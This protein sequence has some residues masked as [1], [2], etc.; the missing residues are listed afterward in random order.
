M[1]QGQPSYQP[2]A[3]PRFYV[4]QPPHNQTGC[5]ILHGF[6]ASPDEVAWLGDDLAQQG[7]RVLV[8]RLPGHGSQLD[9]MRRMRWRDWYLHALD[10]YE[11]L[12]QQCERVVVIGHSMG[13]LLA[14]LIAAERPDSISGLVIAGSPLVLENV[15]LAYTHWI[16]LLRPHMDL[17]NEEREQRI[18]DIIRAER[19]ARGEG[20]DGRLSYRPWSTRA[21]YEIYRLRQAAYEHLP[22]VSTRTL[23]LYGVGDTTAPADVMIPLAQG[24]LS[25]ITPETYILQEG[26][27]LM[28]QDVGRDEAFRAVREFVGRIVRHG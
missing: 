28:F 7:Y 8:P 27:H 25:A 20:D 9:D 22:Q 11:I 3:K 14:A 17:H 13:G 15:Y 19:Q 1:P 6:H 16:S 26:G 5:L 10:A 18:N 2:G 4:G 23:L 12:R 24:R 21:L